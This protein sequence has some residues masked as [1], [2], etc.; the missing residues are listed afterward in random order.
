MEN[1]PKRKVSNVMLAIIVTLIILYTCAAFALEAL[2]A[3]EISPTL[4]GAFFSFCSVELVSLAAIKT[5]KVKHNSDGTVVEEVL[6]EATGDDV[7]IDEAA[8]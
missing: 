7:V 5:S 3:R 1:K 6:E 8:C 4:T 2:F